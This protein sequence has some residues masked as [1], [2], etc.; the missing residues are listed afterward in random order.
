MPHFAKGPL[1]NIRVLVFDEFYE[2]GRYVFGGGSASDIHGPQPNLRRGVCEGL[3]QSLQEF[4]L[5]RLV[6]ITVEECDGEPAESVVVCIE[7]CEDMRCDLV[8]RARVA[9]QASIAST[10]RG[11]RRS[12][13]H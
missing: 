3:A 1:A 11:L 9:A 7:K 13:G 5:G 2:Y 12:L 8:G 10:F 4:S 6:P